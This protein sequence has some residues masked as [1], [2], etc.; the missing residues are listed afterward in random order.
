CGRARARGGARVVD[1]VGGVGFVLAGDVVLRSLCR[2]RGPY[3]GGQYDRG[4]HGAAGGGRRAWRRVALAQ[5]KGPLERRRVVAGPTLQGICG[6]PASPP[7]VVG[8]METPA[9]A[10][11]RLPRACR[12]GLVGWAAP[13]EGRPSDPGRS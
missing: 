7:G 8:R 2:P 10:P 6:N 3:R 12:S 11:A 13:G 4:P 1:G 5:R 9:V